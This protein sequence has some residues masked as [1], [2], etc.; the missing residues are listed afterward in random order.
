MKIKTICICAVQVPFAVGGA[1][2]LAEQL[3]QQLKR[4]GFQSDIF[5]LP[6]QWWPKPAI[7]K[8]ALAWRLLELVDLDGKEIDLIIPT[9]FPSYIIE[10][11]NKVVWLFHQ[12]RELYDLY[13]SEFC[14]FDNTRDDNELRDALIRLD[15]AA[16]EECKKIFT[17]SQ[18]VANR[19]KKFSNFDG[20]PLYPP[21]RL[22][23]KFYSEQYGDYILSVGRLDAL[24]RL[25]KLIRAFANLPSGIKCLI[26]GQG[27]LQ[28][29]L[30][31]IIEKQNLKDRVSLLGFVSEEE[32]VKL[33]ANC[34]AVYFAPTDEDY[35]YI[36]VES[37]LAHKPVITAAD[38]G[39]VIE[40]ARD[41]ENGVICSLEAEE[42][43]N[44]IEYL[45]N[46]KSLCREMGERG[47][48]QVK[49]LSWDRVID[50]LTA[51]Q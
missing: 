31:E 10:H 2:V 18:N 26:A 4:R 47:Y 19:L 45:F 21:P 27:P 32:L 16:L 38:S 28:E 40:F 36:T 11:P 30:E 22:K 17:I 37:F 9:K 48:E 23:D 46:N 24:K 42:L 33:Y 34:F 25:D 50:R 14:N 15:K 39:G 51:I 8:N 13:G 29:E 41:M 6:F 44:K 7:L 1:D 12:H 5:R 35:G 20:E 49:D 43:A 3:N